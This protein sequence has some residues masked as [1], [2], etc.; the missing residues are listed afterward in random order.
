MP[1]A[2]RHHATTAPATRRWWPT[3]GRWREL[4]AGVDRSRPGRAAAPAGRRLG[5]LVAPSLH[6]H[7]HPDPAHH[8]QRA[9][10]PHRHA[11][12][13]APFTPSAPAIPTGSVLVGFAHYRVLFAI[14]AVG[15]VAAV[16]VLRTRHDT[17][18]TA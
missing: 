15:V 7:D 13:T 18:G 2:G 3:T 1:R 11:A 4:R 16:H 12:F 14:A 10:R 6:R 5:G 17:A 9:A 8:A